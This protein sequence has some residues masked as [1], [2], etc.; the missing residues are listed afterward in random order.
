MTDLVCLRE[1]EILDG[2]RSGELS[3]EQLSH[4]ASCPTCS[5]LETVVSFLRREAEALEVLALPEAGIVWRRAQW[6]VAQQALERATSPIRWM[7]R[8][9]YLLG[10]AA[11]AW[12]L[13][14]TPE[15]SAWATA[16]LHHSFQLVRGETQLTAATAI[17]G[18]AGALLCLIL[19]SCYLIWADR[20]R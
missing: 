1:Q 7:R 17:A 13:F 5:D 20:V 14:A 4:I 15:G 9:A 12:F 3:V 16:F 8:S 2:L 11:I 19:G 10:L 6:R 18:L